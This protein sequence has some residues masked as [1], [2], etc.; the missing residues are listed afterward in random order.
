MVSLPAGVVIKTAIDVAAV[1][2]FSLLNELKAKSFN[3]YICITVQGSGGIEDGTLVFDTGKI[4]AAFYDYLRYDKKLVGD[5]AMARVF[6][7]SA[8]KTGVIDIYQ[9]TNEQVQLILAFNENAI[10]IPGERDIARFKSQQFSAEYEKQIEAMEPQGSKSDLL[11]KYK[12]GDIA[13]E[14]PAGPK[15]SPDREPPASDEEDLLAKLKKKR[16][17]K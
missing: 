12:L 17:E 7:A 8:A 6:N 1:D 15:P 4:V 10:C 2:F 16:E 13:S 5:A 3:G 11:K 9:L 14:K